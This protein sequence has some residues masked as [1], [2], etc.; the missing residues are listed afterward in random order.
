M[1]GLHLHVE[2]PQPMERI[3]PAGN[4]FPREVMAE[5]SLWPDTGTTEGL[6]LARENSKA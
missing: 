3:V 5:I 2:S 6:A 1:P 4:S